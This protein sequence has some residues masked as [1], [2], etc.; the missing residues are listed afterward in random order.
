M[1]NKLKRAIL[2]SVSIYYSLMNRAQHM[3]SEALE[4][5]VCRYLVQFIRLEKKE[6]EEIVF[7]SPLLYGR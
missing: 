2:F 4:A 5:C 3:F 7:I 1:G 6:T